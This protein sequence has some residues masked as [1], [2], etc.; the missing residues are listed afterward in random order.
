[1]NHKYLNM[2]TKRML[3]IVLL[4]I[5]ILLIGFGVNSMNSTG[6]EIAEIFGQEDTSGMFSVG[7]GALLAIVGVVLLVGKKR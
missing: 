3:S 5:G 7:V 6:S 1:M 4:V 2:D